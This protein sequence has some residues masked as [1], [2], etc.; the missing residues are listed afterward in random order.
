MTKIDLKCDRSAGELGLSGIKVKFY[1][2]A[3]D[4]VE[5]THINI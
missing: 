1:Q 5:A 4:V 3:W 2:A